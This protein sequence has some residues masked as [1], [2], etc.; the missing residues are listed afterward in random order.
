MSPAININ[1]DETPDKM[2]PVEV[3]IRTLDVKDVSE[4]TTAAG[5]QK[6]TA[7]LEVNEPDAEDHERKMWDQFILK[8]APARVKFKQFCK[9]AGHPGTGE[10]VDPADLIGCTV[11]AVVKPR[12][13][14]DQD[15]GETV[16][17]TQV[18]SYIFEED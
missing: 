1:L 9:S 11:K 14:E 18:K 16:E 10:G 17:T 6:W 3:G 4:G 5:D 12:T 7:E 13:Y 2:L 15:T 8:H